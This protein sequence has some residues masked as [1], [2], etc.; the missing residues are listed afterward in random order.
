MEAM[1]SL[2]EL[3][4]GLEPIHE[5]KENDDWIDDCVS[6]EAVQF[7]NAALAAVRELDSRKECLLLMAANWAD[8]LTWYNARRADVETV[9]RCVRRM[10][11]TFGIRTANRQ[12]WIADSEDAAARRLLGESNDQE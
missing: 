11:A 12:P 9:A 3:A 10:R 8:H 2:T 5:G 4:E 6:L 7:Y 1:H